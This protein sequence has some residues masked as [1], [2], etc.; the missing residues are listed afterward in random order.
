MEEEIINYIS[1]F[2]DLEEN[3][4]R[5]MARAIPHKSIKKG[6]YL[7]KEGEISTECYFVMKG[8]VRQYE[9]IDGDEKT[10]YFYT[11]EEAL[12]AFESANEQKPCQF[13]WVC[14]EDTA[15]VIGRFNE[16]DDFY[17]KHPKMEAFARKFIG[18]DFGRYQEL[19]SSFVTLTPTERY[20]HLL[21]KRPGLANRVPQYQLAS[22]LGIKPE[23]LSRIRKKL[24]SQV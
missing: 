19:I 13:S 8:L 3:E 16:L 20:L 21:D 11:E 1:R 5:E 15:V 24:A 23:T 17:E 22:F 10:T 4:A 2:V 12:V 7:L 18:F 6:E 14:E 9:T